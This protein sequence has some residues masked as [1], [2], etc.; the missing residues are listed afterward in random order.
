MPFEEPLESSCFI[1]VQMDTVITI[2]F[3]SVGKSIWIIMEFL[4]KSML[5]KGQQDILTPYECE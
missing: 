3:T 4:A 2:A 1:S 5:L